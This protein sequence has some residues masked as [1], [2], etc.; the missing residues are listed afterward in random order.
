MTY[1]EFG[2]EADIEYN[3]IIKVNDVTVLATSSNDSESV[4]E[5]LGRIERHNFIDNELQR[6]YESLPEPIKDNDSEE[7]ARSL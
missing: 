5:G 4:E 6:Q 2:E 7:Y 3:L 1:K